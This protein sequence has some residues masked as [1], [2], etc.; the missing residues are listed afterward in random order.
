MADVAGLGSAL[1]AIAKQ[2]IG[3]AWAGGGAALTAVGGNLVAAQVA[4][5]MPAMGA[6]MGRIVNAAV[7]AGV[8]VGASRLVKDPLKRRQLMA[9]GLAVAAIELLS[10]GKTYAVAARVPGLNRL[11]PAPAVGANPAA[12]LAARGLSGYGDNGVAMVEDEPV[13]VDGIAD[14][15]E[16]AGQPA[17]DGTMGE[18]VPTYL[19]GLGC[20]LTGR[21][22]ELTKLV[23]P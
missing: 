15:G 16:D 13:A 7:F 10:P 17:P 2:P 9:G 5:V 23:T 4:R 3:L 20:P 19:D 22:N 6:G 21:S 8:A 14:D 1:A 18:L 11:L 12:V